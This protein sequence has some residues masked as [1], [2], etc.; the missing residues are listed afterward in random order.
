MRLSLASLH[1]RVLSGQIDSLVGLGRVLQRRGHVVTIVTPFESEGLLT[2]S[3]ASI[4]TGPHSLTIAATRMLR[5]L[6]RIVEA[7]QSSDLVHFAL[8]TPAFSAVADIVQSLVQVPVVVAYEGHLAQAHRVLAWARLQKS[9]KT[10]LPLWGINNGAFARISAYRC[11][12]YIVSSDYQRREL[13]KLGAPPARV[14]VLPNVVEAAKL[15]TGGRVAARQ[16]LHLPDDRP[17]VGYIGHFNDVKGVDILAHAFTL[18]ADE[19]PNVTLALAWSGQG[20]P[21]PVRRALGHVADRVSWLGKVHVGRFLAAIDVLALPYRHTAGQGAFPSLV[22]EALHAGCPLTTSRLPLIEEIVVNGQTGM[23]SAPDNATELASHLRALLSSEPAREA[24][25]R[26]QTATATSRFSP[27]RLGTAYE[28][29]Y[30]SL[31]PARASRA[32][33]AA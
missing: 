19:L 21:E 27:E 16:M 14:S 8:P 22:L 32:V 18:L 13:E 9:W 15:R 31:L 28:R 30:Q 10:L 2:G 23:L 24:M 7:A 17:T 6:P 1:P 26:A 12:A 25:R 33:T 29:V 11:P 3:L 20:N 4:D 5:S